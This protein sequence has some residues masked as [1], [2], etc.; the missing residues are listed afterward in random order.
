MDF[1]LCS[2]RAADD[3]G[4][5]RCPDAG[6]RASDH[7]ARAAE[8]LAGERISIA[9]D[10]GRRAG[11][12]QFA[13]QTPGARAQIDDVVGALDS[14]LVVLDDEHGV[15]QVAQP[16]QRV[17]QPLVVARMQADG[18]SSSTYSTPRSREPICVARRMRCA[19]PPESVA[20]ERSRLR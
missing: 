16:R 1:R 11:G 9:R 15:A 2:L 17:E 14:L 10:L 18:G 5:R 3:A 20:A 7:G 8:V 6:N 19:S 13:A 4:C 12:H